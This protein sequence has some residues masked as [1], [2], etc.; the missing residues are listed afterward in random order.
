MSSL[1]AVD[2]R[3]LEQLF[4]MSSGYVLDFSDASFGEFFDDAAGVDIH[5][6]RYTD[7]GTSKANKMREF[8]RLEP[9][10]LVG[11]TLIDLV[12]QWTPPNPSPED[13]A[14]A[15][16]CMEAANR[17]LAAGPR[18]DALKETATVF[19]AGHLAE[20][21][22]RIEQSIDTDPGLAIGTAKELVETCCKTILTERG[23]CVPVA[24]DIPKL[25]KAVC[26]ELRLVPEGV[27]EEA[28]GAQTI[29]VLLSNLATI[30][31]GLAEIRGLYGTGHGKDGRAKGLTPRHARLAVGAATTLV[32][33]LFETH[34]QTK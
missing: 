27:A 24:S 17:L 7:R 22:R 8:W 28:R 15:A 12:E 3:R 5:S 31:Q 34:E 9:D 33:F 25:T 29:K 16:Q 14:L 19:N 2:K 1:G 21:I 6:P 10:A 30:A 4:G 18:L 23:K 26:R 11:R 20:Q 13:A 32:S